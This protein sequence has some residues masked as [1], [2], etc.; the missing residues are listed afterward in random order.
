MS[1]CS[2]SMF[3]VSLKWSQGHY[4][5]KPSEGRL[6]A[7]TQFVTPCFRLASFR[8]QLLFGG[9]ECDAQPRRNAALSFK[10]IF[11]KRYKS[12][13]HAFTQLQSATPS[14]RFPPSLSL[15]LSFLILFKSSYFGLRYPG[16]QRLRR[17]VVLSGVSSTAAEQCLQCP[18]GLEAMRKNSAPLRL[19]VTM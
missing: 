3:C 9:F 7:V 13:R 1:T 14:E 2:Q 16:Y 12:V 5:I 18:A 19:S 8:C 11:L 17:S 4:S 10:N 15:S 6:C